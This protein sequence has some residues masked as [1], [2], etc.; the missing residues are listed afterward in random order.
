MLILIFPPI[1]I[2]AIVSEYLRG[3]HIKHIF[4]FDYEDPIFEEQLNNF[5]FDDSNYTVLKNY[6]K[7]HLD[8][9]EDP[10]FKLASQMYLFLTILGKKF[11]I[12]EADKVIRYSEKDLLDRQNKIDA[13]IMGNIN[14][15]KGGLKEI[16]GGLEN[17][18]G[19]IQNHLNKIGEIGNLNTK[20]KK[21]SNL[22][23]QFIQ[24][25]ISSNRYISN[26]IDKASE[27]INFASDR[28][29][30]GYDNF[31]NINSKIK[32]K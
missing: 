5:E 3:L 1:K 17:L 8:I 16:S 20:I 18:T 19:G 31:K 14:Q 6:F 24:D 15:L 29:H 2:L 11:H 25:Q 22:S 13:L 21:L 12:P 10:Y 23:G 7:E 27:K 26:V 4:K 30:Q 32:K 9:Y 28:L